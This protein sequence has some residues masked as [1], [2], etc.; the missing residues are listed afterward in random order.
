MWWWS[1]WWTIQSSVG[2][3][4]DL[5][6]WNNNRCCI[7]WWSLALYS[8]DAIWCISSRRYGRDRCSWCICDPCSATVCCHAEMIRR[9]PRPTKPTAPQTSAGAHTVSS[10]AFCTRHPFRLSRTTLQIERRWKNITIISYMHIVFIVLA[11]GNGFYFVFSTRT[12]TS[13]THT[14][15]HSHPLFIV[16][17]H[18]RNS[19]RMKRKG[20]P[21]WIW[22]VCFVF[23]A[24]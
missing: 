4:Y 16:N 19:F 22:F 20:K 1:N 11:C 12:H 18:Y 7:D 3:D 9:A 10:V 17:K 23:L 5:S 2:H 14:L 8:R 21:I 24:I 6:L 15:T 13:H